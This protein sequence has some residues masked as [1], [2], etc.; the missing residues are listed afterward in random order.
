MT[1][2]DIGKAAT[3]HQ[4]ASH[5]TGPGLYRGGAFGPGRAIRDSGKELPARAEELRQQ[6]VMYRFLPIREYR[7]KEDVV[8]AGSMVEL[9]HQGIHAY[10]LIVPSGGGLVMRVEGCP[11]QVITPNSP[12]GKVLMGHKAGDSVSVWA[13]GKDRVYRVMGLYCIYCLAGSMTSTLE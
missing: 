10:Y 12:L 5:R 7:N 6:L 8:C 2:F 11:V 4:T 13:G 9:E 3:F 1:R